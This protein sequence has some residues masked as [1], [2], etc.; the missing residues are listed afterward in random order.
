VTAP[1]PDPLDDDR[2]AALNA[3]RSVVLAALPFLYAIVFF[4]LGWR[5]AE[6]FGA[7]G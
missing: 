4:W 5:C 3:W 6:I 2:A 1:H 7:A